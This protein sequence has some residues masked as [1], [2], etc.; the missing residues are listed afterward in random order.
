MLPYP[1]SGD[2]WASFTRAFWIIWEYNQG[3]YD[4]KNQGLKFKVVA[5]VALLSMDPMEPERNPWSLVILK[6]IW[7]R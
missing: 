2:L 7:V 5:H 3:G 6:V 1:N 4:R